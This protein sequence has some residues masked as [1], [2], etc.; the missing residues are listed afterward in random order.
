MIVLFSIVIV[1]YN[2]GEYLEQ[3]IQSVIK[4]TYNNY[5]LIIVDGGSTDNSVDIIK[6]YSENLTWWVSEPD[7]GQSDAFNKGFSHASGDYYVWLNADDL[8]LPKT[9]E[10]IYSYIKKYPK[11]KWF[12][13]NTIY[14]DKDNI[15]WMA[16]KTPSYGKYVLRHG[17]IEIGSPSTFFH[18]SL[19]EKCGPFVEDYHNLMDIDLW[20]KFINAGYVLKRVNE[21]GWAFRHHEASKTSSSLKGN[22][23]ES[24]LK[25][26][27]LVR[28]ANNC[29]PSF[30]IRAYQ[31]IRK[32]LY[33]YPISYY[34]T[35]KFGGNNI[36][37]IEQ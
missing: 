33:S 22:P 1:N 30:G 34:Y 27:L 5:E 18:R 24:F 29:H 8:M 9:L 3:A 11:Y 17:N 20:L 6:N 23:S 14:I 31:K 13:P 19:Y 35:K 25:E 2:S 4:Q 37:I 21:F 10:I 16:Y 15:I 26:R 32:V 36:Y 12:A 28:K 7:K